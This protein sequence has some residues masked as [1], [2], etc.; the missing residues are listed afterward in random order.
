MHEKPEALNFIDSMRAMIIK[1]SDALHDHP[2]SDSHDYKSVDL[3]TSELSHHGFEV[4]RDLAGMNTAR[5]CSQKPD[6]NL[7][8]LR[9][10]LKQIVVSVERS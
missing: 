6:A 10:H 5:R 4:R 9:N 7:R 8:S 3:P 1:I 2:E